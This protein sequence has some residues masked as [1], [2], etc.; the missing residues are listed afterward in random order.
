MKPWRWN[1]WIVFFVGGALLAAGPAAA[2]P[3]EPIDCRPYT[4]VDPYIIEDEIN[5]LVR[6][7][8]GETM[9][10]YGPL[11]ELRTA[12]LGP[13]APYDALADRYSGTFSMAGGFVRIDV[14]FQ[15]LVNPPGPALEG[16]NPMAFGD[17]PL[18]AF[19]EFDVDQNVD[20][21]GEI[22]A[23]E[24]R[25]NGN[26]AR[27]AGLPSGP[28]FVDRVST[29]GADTDF[30]YETPPWI[31]RSGEDFHLAVFHEEIIDILE[32]TGNGDATFDAGE[33][34]LLIGTF[35]HRAHGYDEYCLGGAYQPIVELLFS[36]N[37]DTDRT[38]LT[39]VL[40]LTHAA[41][42]EMTGQWAEAEDF[43]DLNAYSIHE[44]LWNLE[45]SADLHMWGWED[46]EELILPWADQDADDFLEPRAWR[47]TFLI[48][49]ALPAPPTFGGRFVHVDIW[50][51]VVPGDF[52]GD[53]LASNSD[54]ELAAEYLATH[55]GDPAHDEDGVANGQ[56]DLIDFGVRFSI[57]DVNYDGLVDSFDT[58]YSMQDPGDY[59]NDGDVDLEDVAAF[60]RCFAAQQLDPDNLLLTGCLDAF[61]LDL[62][63]DVDTSDLA[64]FVPLLS[65]P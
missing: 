17:C 62:D 61:D 50:P 3:G 33:T 56:V 64:A 55:D 8:D 1:P 41:Y 51:N 23:P 14:I 58:T 19:V 10:L 38:T 57:Y 53:G 39:L 46:Y 4:E 25:F 2:R 48:S 52:N 29:D 32:L 34:W 26:A 36:H 45:V 7:T 6:R 22:L 49:T 31:D 43:D 13:W 63:E 5:A 35:F 54:A 9:D 42:E 21:G 24:F 11:P 30:V 28:R 12:R 65:G 20:S 16:Y 47:P 37:P 44:A 15:G 60:Q 40:P 18:Y 59:E 27:F